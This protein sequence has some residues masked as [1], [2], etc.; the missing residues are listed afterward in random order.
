MSTELI[1][2]SSSRS[3]VQI[4]LLKDGYL[5]ELQ[6]EAGGSQFQVGD[7]YFG[8]VRKVVPGLNA[9]FVD[10]GYEKDAFLHYHDLGPQARSLLKYQKRTI[11]GRQKWSLESFER[12]ADINKNGKIDE[13]LK[14]GMNILV[15]V[16]KEPISTKGPRISSEISIAG[17]YLV[18]MPFSERISVSSKIPD[19]EEGTRLRRLIQSIRPQGLWCDHSDR[20][21]RKK[22]GRPASGYER[23]GEA[24]EK[25]APFAATKKK[26]RIGSSPR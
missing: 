5:H 8:K 6:K 21:Y 23:P 25:H 15:Q 12:E 9:A 20:G 18:L 16:T 10:V 7:I 17:R 11:T 22:S 24:V 1:I 2:D 4:A 26:R 19:E 14:K 3:D 13:I